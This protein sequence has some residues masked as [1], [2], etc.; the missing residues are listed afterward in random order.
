M[1]TPASRLFGNIL[2]GTFRE[3]RFYSYNKLWALMGSVTTCCHLSFYVRVDITLWPFFNC[4]ASDWGRLSIPEICMCVKDTFFSLC[5]H[6]LTAGLILRFLL[7]TGDTLHFHSCAFEGWNWCVWS[8]E[9]RLEHVS[10]AY[11]V[12]HY[13]DSAFDGFEAGQKMFH[14]L[15]YQIIV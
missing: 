8:D 4:I 9:M 15:C 14:H 12:R 3:L 11:K 13:W 6:S 7:P 5:G 10:S 1:L 2:H